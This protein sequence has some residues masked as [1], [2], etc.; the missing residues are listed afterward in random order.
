MRDLERQSSNEHLHA[1]FEHFDDTNRLSG[2]I[3]DAM[4]SMMSLDEM[5]FRF[6]QLSGKIPDAMG[7]MKEL[8]EM[9]FS[10]NQLSRTIPDAIVSM[11]RLTK[12]AIDHT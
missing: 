2:K 3:P 7:S 12:I 5:I 10:I 11:K 8:S 6:N 9:D 1:Q 4:G